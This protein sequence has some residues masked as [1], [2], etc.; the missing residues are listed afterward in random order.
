MD[1]NL[2]LLDVQLECVKQ[3]GR[4]QDNMNA[5]YELYE[6]DVSEAVFKNQ[7][8]DLVGQAYQLFRDVT[9]FADMVHAK[10]FGEM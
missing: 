6:S 5:I 1:D 3:S 10:K 9:I 2:E 4:W 7:M 8:E